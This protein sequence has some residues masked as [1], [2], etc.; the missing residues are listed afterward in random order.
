MDVKKQELDLNKQEQEQMVESQNQQ[1]D[2]CRL[3]QMVKLQQEQQKQM[4]GINPY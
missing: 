3:K 1:R 4:H 2:I